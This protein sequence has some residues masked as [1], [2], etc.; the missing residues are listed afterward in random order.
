MVLV[1]RIDWTNKG[2]VEQGFPITR[3]AGSTMELYQELVQ[4]NGEIPTKQ[5]DFDVRKGLTKKPITTSNQMSITI[6]HS[7]INGTSWFMKMLYRVESDYRHWVEK[8]GPVGDHVRAAKG[9][10]FYKIQEN[11]GLLLDQCSSSGGKGGTST[12]GPQGR[13]FFSEELIETLHELTS[14]KNNQKYKDNLLILHQQL[15]V[16]LRVISCSRKIDLPKFRTLCYDT[17]MNIINNFPFALLNHT[18]HGTI[19]HSAELIELNGGYGLGSLSEECLESNNKDIRNF[20]QFLCRKCSPLDQL[21]DVMSRL[22]E[23]SD[24]KILEYINKVHPKKACTEC[25]SD[26]H[27]IRSHARKTSSP[28]RWYDSLVDDLIIQ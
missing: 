13:R 5:G 16:V 22:L 2:K 3:S 11:T 15:S 17:T 19:H 23:R 8:S 26:E 27:T 18:L 4:E 6:T 28:L 10:V 21:T 1:V 7:W 25:G 12:N 9:R 24:P 14:K 20:L